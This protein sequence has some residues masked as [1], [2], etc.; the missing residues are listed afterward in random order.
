[1]GPSYYPRPGEHTTPDHRCLAYSAYGTKRS[2]RAGLMMSVDWDRAEVTFQGRGDR[3]YP[4]TQVGIHAILESCPMAASAATVR[5]STENNFR[6][7]FPIT[8]RER[9]AR[10]LDKPTSKL[11][12]RI[13]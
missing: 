1:M 13:S 6:A 7:R 8:L 11:N 4:S 3:F 12:A 9:V 5:V 2:S 10:R